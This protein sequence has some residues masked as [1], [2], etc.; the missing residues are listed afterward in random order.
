VSVADDEAGRHS[1]HFANRFRVARALGCFALVMGKQRSL[2]FM[3]G[4]ARISLSVGAALAAFAVAESA[5]AATPSTM[6][7]ECRSYAGR[8]LGTRLP[9]IETKYEGQ[10]TDGTHAV[11]GTA[12]V[13]SRVETFQCSFNQ[14]GNRVIRF[15]VNRNA[16][17]LPLF[18]N[19][20]GQHSPAETACLSA[21]AGQVGA[22]VYS[23]SVQRVSRGPSR[24]IVLVDV[25]GAQNAWR[26][27][28]RAGRV[29]QVMYMGSG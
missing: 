2:D 20:P 1:E 22:P 17:P 13:G 19:F 28:Y 4:K 29:L 5:A 11:N 9:N 7:A 18:P 24:T 27:A 26:C 15:V 8:S 23:L 14:S 25:P 3:R 21:V 12:T 10:R 16:F 6:M